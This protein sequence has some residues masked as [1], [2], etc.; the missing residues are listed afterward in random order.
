MGYYIQGVKVNP[1]SVDFEWKITSTA[2]DNTKVEAKVNGKKTAEVTLENDDL[3]KDT[4]YIFE[5]IQGG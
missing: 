2:T 5:I 4:T 3:E 1:S